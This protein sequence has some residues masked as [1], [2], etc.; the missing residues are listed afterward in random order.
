MSMRILI[1]AVWVSL[2]AGCVSTTTGAPKPVADDEDAAEY[3]YQLGAR[4]YQN[5]K[6]EL[7]RDRLLLSIDFDSKRAITHSTLA[8]TYESLARRALPMAS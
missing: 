1:V 3:N 7:A 2:L 5:G 4:Y 6:Y 8:L